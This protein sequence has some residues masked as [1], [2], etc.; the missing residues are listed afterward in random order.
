MSSCA[1]YRKA[2]AALPFEQLGLCGSSSERRCAVRQP[3]LLFLARCASWAIKSPRVLSTTC[4]SRLFT[5][6]PSSS[7]L[8]NN[9]RG[10]SLCCQLKQFL[11]LTFIAKCVRR[12]EIVEKSESTKQEVLSGQFELKK[13][14]GYNLRNFRLRICV[15]VFRRYW[16]LQPS[17]SASPLMILSPMD[18]KYNAQFCFYV[19]KNYKGR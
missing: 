10:R 6:K 15:V 17:L 16:P 11:I 9:E 7:F 14:E 2:C 8:R 19:G 18:R 3:C 5:L 4:S 13:A 12:Q 1:H